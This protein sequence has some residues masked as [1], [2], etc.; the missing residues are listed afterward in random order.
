MKDW[1]GDFR[2]IL[3]AYLI[4]PVVRAVC[5]TLRVKVVNREGLDGDGKIACMWHGR[6]VL[7]A[8][9]KFWSGYSVIISHSRD[10]EMQARIYKKLGFNIIRGSTGRGGARAAVESI[11]VLRNGG[12]M[13]IT[14]DGPK[15]PPGVVQEGVVYLAKKAGVPLIPLGISARPRLL[16]KSWD[17][18]LV[19]APFGKAT[20][21]V[22]DPISISRDATHEEEEAVRAKLESEMRR[23]ENEAERAMGFPPCD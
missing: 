21:I 13:A 9:G 7:P 20:I 19:P 6:T 15:G 14:P 18:F 5:L 17:R 10:G 4:Y 16:A 8:F 2:P 23:L 3:L 22:G 12:R 1:W 11:R